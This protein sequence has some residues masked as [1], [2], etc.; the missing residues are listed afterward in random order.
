M[1]RS[2]ATK[3]GQFTTCLQLRGF[4]GERSLR[5]FQ[6]SRKRSSTMPSVRD[7]PGNINFVYTLAV[8]LFRKFTLVLLLL[9]VR[10]A[11]SA[12]FNFCDRARAG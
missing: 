7:N 1:R 6:S 8:D 4:I 9:L 12:L 11:T 3:C 2:V 5:R 10:E